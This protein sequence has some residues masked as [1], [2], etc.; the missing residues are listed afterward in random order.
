MQNLVSSCRDLLSP[1]RRG[2][3]AGFAPGGVRPLTPKEKVA[4]IDEEFEAAQ[5]AFFKEYREAKTDD[6]KDKL[7]KEKYPKPD[8]W[9]PRLYEIAKASAEERRAPRRPSSGS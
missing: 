9:F 3:G 5:D 4:A 2:P 8:K 7:F 1:G 6:E